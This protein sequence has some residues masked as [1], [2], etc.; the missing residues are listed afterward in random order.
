MYNNVFKVTNEQLNNLKNEYFIDLA[1]KK[2]D[3]TN[4]DMNQWADDQKGPL[5]DY[6]EGIKK[7]DNIAYKE[8][9]NFKKLNEEANKKYLPY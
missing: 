6:L 4:G 1:K 7:L 8:I 3:E 2:L 9:E 5:N